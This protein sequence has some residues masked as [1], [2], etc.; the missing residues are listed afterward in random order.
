MDLE[1]HPDLRPPPPPD[2][3][4]IRAKSQR[5]HATAS[6]NESSR[7]RIHRE[8]IEVERASTP[9]EII[10]KRVTAS[11]TTR[12][13]WLD[14][15]LVVQ[16]D[17]LL[18]ALMGLRLER[19]VL[20][21]CSNE[22]SCRFFGRGEYESC[23]TFIGLY[24]GD[25]GRMHEI[26]D[27]AS[28]HLALGVFVVPVWPGQG[29]K[30]LPGFSPASQKREPVS[31]YDA[32]LAH[33]K[34]V[35]DLP[36][37]SFSLNGRPIS[38]PCAI[39]AVVADFGYIGR[40]KGKNGMR[41]KEHRWSLYKVPELLTIERKLGAIPTVLTQESPMA[42]ELAPTASADTKKC[43]GP[44]EPSDA[45]PSQGVSKWDVWTLE[46][47]ARRYPHPLVVKLAL[48]AAGDGVD[49]FVGKLAKTVKQ[50]RDWLTPDQYDECRSNMMSDVAAGETLGPYEAPPFVWYRICEIFSI[51]KKKHD[52]ESKLIRLISNFAEGNDSSINSLCWSP[53]LIGFHCGAKHLRDRIA[54]CGP[55]AWC[56]AADI[57]KCF[58]RQRVLRRL[59]HLF[60]YKVLTK[61]HGLE[62]FVDLSTPFGWSPSEWGWQVI[63]AII[64]WELR[65][66]GL[67]DT[68]AYVDN[69]FLIGEATRNR[70]KC[71]KIMLDFFKEIGVELHELM[72][73]RHFKG[74]GWDWDLD[75]MLMICPDDKYSVI[76]KYLQEWVAAIDL[77]LKQLQTAVGILMWLSAGFP[78]AKAQVGHLVHLRTAGQAIQ[79]RT[80]TPASAIMVKVNKR[81]HAVFSLW[82][83]IL[84]K[85]RRKCVIRS[86]FNPACGPQAR[87]RGDASTEWGCGG[88]ALTGGRL[89]GFA[90]QWT[91]EEQQKAII[92]KRESTGIMEVW[93]AE[94]W[95]QAFGER[96]RA[97][98]VQYETD[99]SPATYAIESAYSKSAEM[100][101]GVSRIW[102]ECARLEINLRVQHIRG[103]TFNIIADHL[104]H[105]RIAEAKWQAMTELGLVM[106]VVQLPSARSR[107][108]HRSSQ[109]R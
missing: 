42:D 83:S 92:S 4:P 27:M 56:W 73:P 60:V 68:L 64:M 58:R 6:S 89:Y 99:S 74:L 22:S 80:R 53:R 84:P 15:S 43:D 13:F 23:S 3:R 95:L 19:D 65:R 70:A 109:R 62:Y 30:I 98:R 75:A 78:M 103:T 91:P 32:L 97:L 2:Y 31:W 33:S 71:E 52:P 82:I 100:L 57:P 63:L 59:M 101:E 86:G 61:E 55:G 108:R 90:Q 40:Y 10:L 81:A 67:S 44:Q 17:G 46:K 45:P 51:P 107:Q 54:Q 50:V 85:W 69:F 76:M 1:L 16:L 24:D 47:F 18:Y 96:T 72:G 105:N 28:K 49:P 12:R 35:V 88:W 66:R 94:R 36:R 9:P 48:E 20:A 26:V 11:R 41:R 34:L 8:H 39:Q 5:R 79:R 106:D 104:S 7:Q 21:T 38:A 87:G 29:P 14:F 37:N 102:R 25:W 77:S 93:A